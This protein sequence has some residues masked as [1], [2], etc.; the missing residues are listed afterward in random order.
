MKFKLTKET[1]QHFWK[2]LYRIEALTDFWDVKKWD[3]WW[4]IE[5]KENLDNSW[6]A[7]VYWD[8]RVYW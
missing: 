2:T 4:F 6:N 3:K 7:W 8:A 5:K 1:I